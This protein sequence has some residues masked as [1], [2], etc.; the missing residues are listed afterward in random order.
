MPFKF[1]P[2]TGELDLVNPPITNPLLFK[3]SITLNSDFPTSAEVENGWFYTILADV[4]DNDVTKTNTGQ[5]FETGDEIAWNGTNW[6]TLGNENIYILADGT[7]TLT[8]NWD[9]GDF[10]ITTQNITYDGTLTDGTASLIGGSFT[11]IKLGS[12]TDNGFVKTSGGDGTLSVDT[13][14]YLTTISGGDHSI[15]SNLDYASAGHTG[16]EP[17]VTKGDLTETTSDVLTI[18]GGTGAVIGSGLTIEVDQADTDNAGYLSSTDWDTFNNKLDSVAHTDLTDMP[19]AIN[20]DHDDRYTT[21]DEWDENGFENRTD[22]TLTWTDTGPNYTLSIQPTGT[23]FN[24][25]VAGVKYITTG[26]TVQIDN[27]KEGIHIIYYDGETLTALANPT[28]AQVASIIRTKALASIIQWDVSEA[29][30]TY[31]GEERH[32]MNM[33]PTTHAYL[34]F[35]EGLRYVSGLGLNTMSVDGTGITADAQFGVDAGEVSDEDIFLTVDIVASTTGLPIYYMLGSDASPEWQRHIEAGFS[36]RT[37]D[38]TSTTRLAYNQNNG[39]TWQLT[40]VGNNDFV[41]CHV[42][43]TTEKD[44][45]MIAIMGQ[46]KYTSRKLAREGALSEI[47]T[48]IL[49][50][51]L[52]PESRPIATVIFQTSLTYASAVNGKVVSTDE[53]DNYV[54]WRNEDISRTA[55]ST[56][57]HGSLSG[58]GSDD[59][60]QYSLVDGTR[61]FTGTVGGIT[62]VADADL[63][64][65]K[66]VDDANDT[67]DTAI[68]L[69]TTHRTSDGTNHSYIN[70]DVTTTASPDF[71]GLTVDTDTIYVDSTDHRVGVNTVTPYVDLDIYGLFDPSLFAA[72]VPQF[73]MSSALD[74]VTG[75]SFRNTNATGEG[76]DSRLLMSD[77][78]GHYMSFAMPGVGNIQTNLLGQV[79]STTDFIFNAAGTGRD[80]AIGTTSS[81]E[82]TLATNNTERITIQGDGDVGINDSTPTEK[83]DVG[84]KVR[85]DDFIEYSTPIPTEEALPIIMKMKNKSNGKLDHKTFPSYSV[86]D[87]V[88]KKGETIKKEGVSLSSQ[89]KYLIKAVQE[90]NKKIDI[91]EKKEEPN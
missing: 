64:T 28:E 32:G 91:L 65:K 14:T 21:R 87:V 68:G 26:D 2:L 35:I 30:A 36:V 60:P 71:A 63:S 37:V 39:G 41:L 23:D 88:N 48:L 74:K 70:Q 3:G 22:S 67:Q 31:V 18:I 90:L 53:G 51:L 72:H 84:G 78:T 61:A 5:S 56:T 58:L 79:R 44:K 10:D 47:K 12:L 34:H 46:N 40:D 24:Y 16:F 83:L 75:M 13:N 54:D 9:T 49:N 80:M 38:G 7:R 55:V 27:T 82:L 66:Y 6:T 15:L 86:K 43:A 81:K 50:E 42:F 11:N 1:N 73:A 45:P 77:T 19:S 4:T 85:A 62:P 33:S 69:N 25:W 76:V 17:T 20:T 52:L 29:V 59:H 89:I 57:D 8:G